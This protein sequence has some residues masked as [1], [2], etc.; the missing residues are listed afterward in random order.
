MIC[1]FCGHSLGS[2]IVTVSVAVAT[3]LSKGQTLIVTCMIPGMKQLYVYEDWVM[4]RF[5]SC[6]QHFMHI[7]HAYDELLSSE[8]CALFEK[9]KK[10]TRNH[11]PRY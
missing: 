11:T 2:I 4:C 7:C 9:K 8:E 3:V 10:T 1:D 5:I 6:Y